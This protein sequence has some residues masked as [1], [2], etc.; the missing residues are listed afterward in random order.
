MGSKIKKCLKSYLRLRRRQTCFQTSGNRIVE[1]WPHF[2]VVWT[3]FTGFWGQGVHFW[4]CK[5]VKVILKTLLK[6][7]CLR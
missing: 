1:I 6:D 4:G 5:I 2:Y 3:H 7:L